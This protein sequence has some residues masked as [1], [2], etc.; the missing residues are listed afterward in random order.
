MNMFRAL[1][2]RLDLLVVALLLVVG[3]FA[4]TA[5]PAAAL[6]STVVISQVYGGGGNSGAPLR[7]DF[8]EL[9]NR[10]TTTISLTGWSVQYAS[11]TG[12]GLFSASV[13]VLSGSLAPGQYY[14]V[15]MASGGASGALLPTPDASGNTAMSA[16]AGKV[17]LVSSTTGLACN[18]GSTPC[19]PAQ[20]AMIVDL[21]GWG[22]ANFFEGA[23]APT[24]SNTTAVL[25][26]NSGYV[27]TDN[28]AADFSA[29]AP[30]P[31]TT[32]SPLSVPP[33]I[34]T[35]PVDQTVTDGSSATFTAAASGS[36]VPT[37]KWQ[38]SSDGS[39]WADI[40][41][42]TNT[43]VS[44]TPSISQS[45][46]RYRA[47]FANAYGAAT[48]NVASL[49][50]QAPPTIT[51]QPLDQTV[52]AGQ[53]ATFSAAASGS[54]VPTVKWQESLDG[55]TTWGDVPGAASTSLVFTAAASLSGY[56]YRAVFSN[57]LGTATSVAATLT[58]HTPPTITTQPLDQTVNDGQQVA[59]SA[60]ASGS[61]V[62]TV[63]WQESFDGGATWNDVPGATSTSLV[64]TA[65]APQDGYR[66]R[67]VFTNV[68]GIV[69]TNAATLTVN[70]P[71][72]VISQIYG[73][74]GNVGAILKNDFI[75]LF[76]RG[77][78]TVS[79]AG[80]S[81]QY[82]STI[83]FTWF[84]TNLSGTIA[85]NHYYLI[86]EAQGAGG[87]TDLPTPDASGV[88]T[89]DQ[90][91]GK[92]VLV[93]NQTTILT[94][95]ACPAGSSIVD[96]VGYGSGTNCYEGPG[97]APTL[98]NT[99]AALRLGEG[100]VDTNDNAA[101]FAAVAPNPRNTQSPPNPGLPT[102]GIGAPTGSQT[103]SGA[104][105]TISGTAT[106]LGGSVASVTVTIQRSGDDSYWTGSSWSLTRTWLAASGTASWTYDWTFDPASQDGSPVY[107]VVARATDDVGNTGSTTVT[108]V[109]V[110]NSAPSGASV[111]INGG[112][113]YTASRDVSLTLAAAG[114]AE[115][116]FSNDGVSWSSWEA[117]A[118]SRSWTL[119]A[120]DGVK[121]VFVEYRDA[122]GNAAAAQAGITFDGT[123]PSGASVSINGGAA[124]TASRDVS[125]TLAAAGAAEMRF[126]NDGVSWSSWEAY[127]ASRSWTLNAGD[128]VKT[129]FVEYRDAAG[130]TAPARDSITLHAWA[131]SGASIVIDG[132]AV[133]ATSRE[134]TLTLYAGGA[135][136]MRF[137]NDGLAWSVWEAYAVSRS[138]TLS[139]GDGPKTVFA[140]FRVAAG[141][142]APATDDII[143]DATVPSGASIVIAGA[144]AYTASRDVSLTL[145]AGGAAEMRFSNDGLA[146]SVWEDYAVSRSWT[147]SAG[148]G[149]KTVFVEYRDAAGNAASANDSIMLDAAAP[150]GRVWIAGGAVAV[151]KRAVTLGCKVSGAAQ[152]RFSNDDLTWSSWEAYGASRSW[153]LSAGDGPKTVFAQFLDEAG[154]VLASSPT[155]VLD[156]RRPTPRGTKAVSVRRGAKATLR[157]RIK[158][159]APNA[160]TATV[161]IRVRT[162]G[163]RIVKTA[164]LKN[165][166]VAK[167]L[168]YRFTCRL[169][170]GDYRYF[171]RATDAAG[172][173][174]TKVAHN[175]LTVR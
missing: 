50:V 81:V 26:N 147:L 51:T 114:A 21:V 3:G 158:D 115:M 124:Y 6:S 97:P 161:R 145:A 104:S 20:L 23:A 61:P 89:I 35:Q 142:I 44:F 133:Y 160:G 150:S 82:A 173:R 111:S 130:N 54:P 24:T 30:N 101:D 103:L 134:V 83:G 59:F 53:Q 13:T 90:A 117:Y 39:T 41:G 48:T 138:W 65:A 157:F 168:K 118:A 58:V 123:A 55:G 109:T 106:D 165:Q 49:I 102:A 1:P 63:K 52:N 159:P 73:G 66:Y 29:G 75:E 37:V 72:V 79:L 96:K 137:S 166:P 105:A 135:S 34:T 64:F 25:R 70:A 120:G 19:T 107:T 148:D 2:R 71:P 60:A 149:P 91:R 171:I 10:G 132:G 45:G 162:L 31:R 57:G 93:T 110:D 170:R 85:P 84:R 121:T 77:T 140:Q 9:F 143:L 40:P 15:Q 76:N 136:E 88:I 128:G 11:A 126:S 122:A 155:T 108:G 154:N 5:P 172:N 47:V 38:V 127:A 69:P 175:T 116:R 156:T 27:E 14:L 113:A 141:D 163:G 62:P 139:A 46:N 125:L 98:S 119:N 67:A 95:T 33:A 28:N 22:N 16:T 169:P 167:A 18:G 12:T 17:V 78:T 56:R 99:T 86:Q 36:P 153:T 32:S 42:V 112:A 80:W 151:N 68:A 94:G 43:T 100:W 131:P 146:W 4:V 7:N 8:V 164:T 144:A 92:V 74:G 174:Q 129:V 87:T 152:M